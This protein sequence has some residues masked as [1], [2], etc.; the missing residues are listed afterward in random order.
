MNNNPSR[1]KSKNNGLPALLAGLLM[2]CSACGTT[3]GTLQGTDREVSKRKAAQVTDVIL[4]EVHVDSDR[5]SAVDLEVEINARKHPQSMYLESV[6]LP[7]KETFVI[8]K[9]TFIPLTSTHVRA[10]TNDDASWI[11]CS[12]LYDGELVV[13]HKSRGNNPRADCEKKFQLGPG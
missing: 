7:Y 3:E 10:R 13:S 6:E 5:N 1:E 4:V 8:P 9:D 2:L 11:S 12:I